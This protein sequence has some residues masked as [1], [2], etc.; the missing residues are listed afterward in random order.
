MIA[1]RDLDSIRLGDLALAVVRQNLCLW[2]VA[3]L[4]SFSRGP[5]LH[6]D[7]IVVGYRVYV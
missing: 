7:S 6:L 5:R 2:F 3:L 1:I 4:E